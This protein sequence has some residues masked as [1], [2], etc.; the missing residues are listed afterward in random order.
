MCN[1]HH[2]PSRVSKFI[3]N[4]H[5]FEQR[6]LGPA[7]AKIL[8]FCTRLQASMFAKEARKN[9]CQQESEHKEKKISKIHIELRVMPARSKATLSWVVCTVEHCCPLFSFH[10]WTFFR[11]LN[12]NVD[13]S[14]ANSGVAMMFVYGPSKS[15]S[16]HTGW[17]VC[18]KRCS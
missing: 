11:L 9:K 12:Q 14:L 13:Y 10:G 4:I 2:F 17:N 1:F 8:Y 3:N 15:T 16:D 7:H 5:K 18:S 6:A